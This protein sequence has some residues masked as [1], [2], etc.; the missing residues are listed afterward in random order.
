MKHTNLA[1]AVSVAVTGAFLSSHAVLAEEA[2]QVETLV[3]TGQKIDRTLQETPASVAVITNKQ[4]QEQNLID[5]YD[6][7]EQTPNVSGRFGTDFAIRG[8][9][10]FNVSGAGNSF[11]TSVYVD[12]AIL[13]LRMI[14]Q[15]GFSAWDVS[16]VEILR[17]P[18]STLQGRNALAGAI[19][20]KTNQPMY[21]WDGKARITLGEYGRRDVA[22]AFGGG[23]I[24]DELAFRFSGERNNHDGTVHN[25]TRGETSDFNENQTYRLKLLYEPKAVEGLTAILSYTYNDSDIGV[26]WVNV[27]LDDPFNNRTTN[28]NAPTFEFTENDIINLEVDYEIDDE[29]TFSSITTYVN[30]DYGY[31]W[32]GDATPLP[33]SILLDD[34]TDKTFSQEFRFV[35]EGERLQGVFG[36]FYSD[37]DVED[38]FSG[39]RSTTLLSLGIPTLLVTPPEFGGIGLPQAVADA[40]LGLYAPADPVQ[41]GTSGLTIQGVSSAAVYADFTYQIDDHWELFGGLR[42]DREEQENK[43]DNIITVENAD[44]L[45]DPTNPLLDPQLAFIIG[46]LNTQLLQMAD[47]ASGVEPLVDADF[48]AFLPKLGV[49][50]NWNSDI[51]THFTYQRGYRSGGVGSNIARATTHEFDPEYTDN[52]EISFRS[53]WLEGDLVA[54]VNLFYL[55]WRDQQVSVQLSGSRFDRETRN[56]GSSEVKGFELELFW[57]PNKNW[58]VFGGLGKAKTEFKDFEI[59]LPTETFDLAGRSFSGAPEW[60]ANI[61]VTYENNG[62]FANV[63]ANYADSHDA[64]NN[65]WRDGLREGDVGFDPK[66]DGRTLVNAR[67]GYR[68]DDMGIFVN[69]TNLFDK[70]Y[71]SGA[72]RSLGSLELG[73]VRQTSLT[74]TADF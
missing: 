74:F 49:T 9:D 22:V 45:P 32:D 53:V 52:Y 33:G 60:T 34:R 61:G 6:V 43:A 27:D 31:E 29:W 64:V 38:Q 26:P 66:N 19:V 72:D 47:A 24:D 7:L 35:Y 1:Q 70:E 44:Q 65:P 54:N 46:A 69:V 14:Q 62:W 48:D 36:A 20:I 71:L 63:N 23:L 4:I 37:L 13:P 56:A 5:L 58:R 11:L 73:E 59:I 15:G 18:Q 2:S 28:F 42:Y 30:S 51:A 8:I 68:W 21:E 50:Y 40:V 39:I 55:D 67:A 17:G 10:A 25:I 3:V 41:L 57:N 16:Q 12:S